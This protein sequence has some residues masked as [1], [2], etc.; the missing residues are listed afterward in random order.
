MELYV[1]SIVTGMECGF[2]ILI[3]KV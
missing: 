3:K 1:T 2:S